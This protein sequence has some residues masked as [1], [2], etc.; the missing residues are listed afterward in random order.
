MY[1]PDGEVME[2][3]LTSFSPKSIPPP[4]EDTNSEESLGKLKYIQITLQQLD[5]AKNTF[6]DIE[7]KKIAFKKNL[8]I[9]IGRGEY[10]DIFC[11]PSFH[12][13]EALIYAD[14]AHAPV[15]LAVSMKT[16]DEHEDQETSLEQD[17]PDHAHQ[18]LKVPIPAFYLEGMDGCCYPVIRGVFEIP[19]G[20]LKFS[21]I[22]RVS[23]GRTV[24]KIMISSIREEATA[25]IKLPATA[26]AVTAGGFTQGPAPGLTANKTKADTNASS[27]YGNESSPAEAGKVSKPL[28]VARRKKTSLILLPRQVSCFS[29]NGLCSSYSF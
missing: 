21:I 16:Y 22:E 2:K 10:P 3:A 25:D 26:K 12:K 7:G 23:R 28:V 15:V 1:L 29:W 20:G 14:D 5:P 4:R 13:K 27:T 8:R 18:L 19:T 9:P 17:G 11:D 6:T 24:G